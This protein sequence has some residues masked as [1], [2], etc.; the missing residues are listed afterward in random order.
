MFSI[1]GNKPKIAGNF[2]LGVW[3]L[4][5]PPPGSRGNA[6]V[7]V[8]GAKPPGATGFSVIQSIF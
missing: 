1:E 8:Q 3:G 6:L 7:G 2:T 5:R 4:H